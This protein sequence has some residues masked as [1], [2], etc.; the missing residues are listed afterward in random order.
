[1]RVVLALS[2]VV[3][4]LNFSVAHGACEIVPVG[5]DHR[6]IAHRV[7]VNDRFLISYPFR[8]NASST[9][10]KLNQASLCHATSVCEIVSVDQTSFRVF[11]GN[12]IKSSHRNLDEAIAAAQK[13]FDEGGCTNRRSRATLEVVDQMVG[14]LAKD[15]REAAGR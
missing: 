2:L 6:T 7:F 15:S 10:R 13:L 9:V 14:A 3:Y 8:D 12:N 1:M 11:S 4:L 5:D